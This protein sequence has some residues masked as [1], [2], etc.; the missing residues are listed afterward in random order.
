MLKFLLTFFPEKVNCP[1]WS[2]SAPMTTWTFHSGRRPVLV[3]TIPAPGVAPPPAAAPV[4]TG[5][6]WLGKGSVPPAGGRLAYRPSARRPVR[7]GSGRHPHPRHQRRLRQYRE[8]AGA[9]HHLSGI[10]R[11]AVVRVGIFLGTG[12]R[13]TH[14]AITPI[15][16]AVR[17]L[18]D[19][20][21][22]MASSRPVRLLTGSDHRPG[23]APVD[24][25]LG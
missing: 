7:C 22:V 3:E 11:S 13:P 24:G 15:P 12:N 21:T 14:C 6:L 19:S 18:P 1:G 8:D 25:E 17:P 9:L 5:R 4:G 2:P 23:M 20:R 10:R 16:G